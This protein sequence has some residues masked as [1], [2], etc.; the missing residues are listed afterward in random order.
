MPA[1][2]AIWSPTKQ[3]RRREKSR[4]LSIFGPDSENED[5]AFAIAA[6]VR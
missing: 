4:R 3:K 6:L 5:D 1:A 2:I